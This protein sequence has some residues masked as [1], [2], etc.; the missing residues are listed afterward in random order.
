MLCQSHGLLAGWLA[1][2]ELLEPVNFKTGEMKSAVVRA[3]STGTE[4]CVE[5]C[6]RSL[7][8]I[9]CGGL[10]VVSSG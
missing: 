6:F 7:D 5:Q 1:A 2:A 10:P 4:G 9:A 8:A 3:G